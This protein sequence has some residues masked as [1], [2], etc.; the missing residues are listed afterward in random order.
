MPAGLSISVV[1]LILRRKTSRLH[2][3]IIEAK[4]VYT[5]YICSLKPHKIKGKTVTTNVVDSTAVPLIT[6]VMENREQ[7]GK[8]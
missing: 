1:I 6:I 2:D 5:I 4:V 3:F 8:L 7:L